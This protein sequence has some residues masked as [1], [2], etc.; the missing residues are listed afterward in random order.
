[1]SRASGACAGAWRRR[2]GSALLFALVALCV[3]LGPSSTSAQLNLSWL[4]NSG[5]QAGTFIQKAVG[6]TGAYGHLSQIPPGVTSYAD[7]T[8]FPAT[9]VGN[10]LNVAMSVTDSV[11]V[12]KVVLY[13]D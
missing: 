5:G 4:D 10:H 1:M 2:S 3:I 11:K 13:V 6:T 8:G 7:P 12:A 9:T